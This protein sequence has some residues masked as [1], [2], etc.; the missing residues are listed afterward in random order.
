M[1]N[2][3]VT[4]IGLF[5]TFTLSAGITFAAGSVR[6]ANT[7]GTG[8]PYNIVIIKVDEWR[9]DQ[10]GYRGHKVVKT[11]NIDKLARAGNIFENTYTVSP[12]CTPSRGSF[13]TGQY[14]M[15]HKRDFVTMDKHMPP[16]QWSYIQD[17]KESGYT[18]ALAGKNHIFN[19]EFMD[20]HFDFRE[21]YTHFGKNHGTITPS[22]Q[23]VYDYRHDE[24]RPEF[25]GETP[26]QGS[27]LLEGLIEGPLPFKKEEC[28]T[29]RIAEDGIRFLR[30]NAKSEKPFFL[31]YSFPDPHWPNVVPKPYY[32]MYDPADMTL[33]GADVD[34]E[35]HPIA[36]YVQS[37]SNGFGWYTADERKRIAATM[38]GQMT[39]IDDS[40]G[41]FMDEMEKLGLMENTIIIFTADHGNFGGH[42]GLIGKTKGFY[43]SLVRI[44]LIVRFPGIENGREFSA[45]VENVDIMPTVMEYLGAPPAEGIHGESFLDVLKKGSGEHRDVIFSE[46]GLNEAPPPVLSI[47]E[48]NEYAKMRK[49]RD[50]ASWFLDYT[51]KGRSAMLLKGDW[52]YCHYVGDREELYNLKNDP[53]ELD[54]LAVLGGHEA[55]LA[56]MRDALLDKFLTA[57]IK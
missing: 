53:L 24:K 7:D 10:F 29:H 13:F 49:A 16:D 43:D 37:I 40:V 14:T 26:D 22:D 6:G 4:R 23:A 51:V 44:P 1:R 28:M 57:S 34:W 54:N 17:L 52:K 15:K 55:K 3:W 19:D 39:F 27:V 18:I 46:I 42:L 9:H 41:L 12:F 50:G 31:K 25:Q 11:P 38:F 33:E 2:H 45:L 36:H 8:K 56:E 5:L 35:T 21:E 48:L 30:E 32:S 47:K 20:E